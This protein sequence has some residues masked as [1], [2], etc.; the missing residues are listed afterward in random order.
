MPPFMISPRFFFISALTLTCGIS[1]AQDQ[2]QTTPQQ[3]KESQL[4]KD[5]STLSYSG[6]STLEWQKKAEAG[7]FEAM[8]RLARFWMP[9]IDHGELKTAQG[10]EASYRTDQWLKK[11][12]STG[13]PAPQLYLERLKLGDNLPEDEAQLSQEIK[14]IINSCQIRAAR[15]D[16]EAINTIAEGPILMTA[17]QFNHWIEPIKVKAQQNDAQAQAELAD[18][19]I[20]SPGA[21]EQSVPQG[22]KWAL[23]SAN[24][25]NID[26]MDIAG[27]AL[28]YDLDGS[29][30]V[31]QGEALLIKAAENGHVNAMQTLL[32]TITREEKASSD[33]DAP[34][35]SS[36]LWNEKKLIRSLCDRGQLDILISRGIEL[37][38]EGKDTPGGMSMLTRAAEQGSFE[39]MDALSTY[40]QDNEYNVPA[41][42]DKAFAYATRLADLGGVNGLLKLSSFYEK[43]LGVEKSPEKAFE[44]VKKA[45]EL[46]V[47]EAIIEYARFLMKGIGCI[48][49]PEQAFRILSDIEKKEPDTQTLN[50][51][52]GYMHEEGIGTQRNL[53]TAF[54]YYTLGAET[55]DPKAMNNLASM[56]EL[57][58]GMPRDMER[59]VEWYRKATE[60]GD[61]DART[62]LKRAQAAL[63][64]IPSH[65]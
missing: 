7:D 19:L 23:K 26:G 63:K 31:S 18:L 38:E 13:H 30:R 8:M 36:T 25:G 51:L 49:N 10:L 45:A 34:E 12:A 6:Q 52:L 28:M 60:A 46:R 47:A 29:G 17:E 33:K 48:P 15:G 16:I 2:P 65:P 14:D 11:A 5:L 64:S 58:S 21:T 35:Q 61:K 50:F 55:G 54:K 62:N 22:I 20:N 24:A 41:S 53:P 37:V 39:A 44:L 57:G 40:Y 27:R 56:Y 9:L 43:G 3:S 1:L 42:P 32:K 4:Q 59:A